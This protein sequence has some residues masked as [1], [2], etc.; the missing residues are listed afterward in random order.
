VPV[1]GDRLG[2]LPEGEHARACRD[3]PQQPDT[4]ALRHELERI[5]FV[6]FLLSPNAT[7]VVSQATTA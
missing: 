6:G 7:W 5:G 4:G 3:Q 1:A 2:Q